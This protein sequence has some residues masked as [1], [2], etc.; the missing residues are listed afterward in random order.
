MASPPLGSSWQTLP[1]TP[2]RDARSALAFSTLV[3]LGT[4]LLL[5]ARL[6]LL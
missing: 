3:L 2:Y 1:A 4:P 5:A 6:R